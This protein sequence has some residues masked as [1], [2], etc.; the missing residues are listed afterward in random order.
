M[1]KN[2]G[3]SS[4][5]KINMSTLS[6]LNTRKSVNTSTGGPYESYKCASCAQLTDRCVEVENNERELKSYY[7]ALV[8][9]LKESISIL[10]NNYIKSKSITSQYSKFHDKILKLRKEKYE[11]KK[12]IIMQQK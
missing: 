4:H 11:L 2:N 1:K 6:L 10:L 12:A 7:E 3:T 9:D 5:D 8:E